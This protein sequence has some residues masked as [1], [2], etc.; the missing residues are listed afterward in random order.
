MILMGEEGAFIKVIACWILIALSLLLIV[1]GRDTLRA[2]TAYTLIDKGG[3]SVI[4]EDR[5]RKNIYN[6][7][8]FRSVVVQLISVPKASHYQAY[9]VGVSGKC[10]LGI[11]SMSRN[12]LT[13]IF[14][15]IAEKLGIPIEY[16]EQAIGFSEAIA[17]REGSVKS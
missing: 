10:P 9:L 14:K 11:Q 2:R 16:A 17:I 1:L 7:G 8:A 12:K 15:P 5:S 6:I 13:G 4:I 3:Q